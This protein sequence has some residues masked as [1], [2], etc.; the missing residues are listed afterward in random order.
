M[1]YRIPTQAQRIE[2]LKTLKANHITALET[3]EQNRI[4]WT[5]SDADTAAEHR[6]VIAECT[7]QINAFYKPAMVI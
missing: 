7:R 1:K 5:E 3:L 4:H 6:R 2:G